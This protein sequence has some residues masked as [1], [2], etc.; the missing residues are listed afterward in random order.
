MAKFKNI[1][2]TIQKRFI[3]EN[4]SAY[5]VKKIGIRREINV[6]GSKFPKWRK[7]QKAALKAER[8]ERK[9]EH[10]KNKNLAD[11]PEDDL[12]EGLKAEREIRKKAREE[13]KQKALQKR[14]RRHTTHL[15]PLLLH[16]KR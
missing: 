14:Y 6:R 8:E 2:L 13:K 5:N 16:Q 1:Y 4:S 3:Y 11:L 10:L 12:E 9:K 15:Y 7:F